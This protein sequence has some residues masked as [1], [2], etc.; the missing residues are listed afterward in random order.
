MSANPLPFSPRHRETRPVL[1]HFACN[2]ERGYPAGTISMV[3]F[4][5]PDDGDTELEL[6][7]IE[8]P[9]PIV[10]RPGIVTVDGFDFPITGLRHH[11]GNLLWDAAEMDVANCLVLARQLL[12]NGGWEPSEWT[13]DGPFS[14]L[15]E[16]FGG[17][18]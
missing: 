12:L 1:V 13:A 4:D 2:D 5:G 16:R 17:Q 14:G 6:D 11:V 10:F 3:Q 15:V 9:V 18:A 7:G 8:A